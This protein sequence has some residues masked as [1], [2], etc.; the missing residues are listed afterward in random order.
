MITIAGIDFQTKLAAE[1]HI[2]EILERTT[3]HALTRTTLTGGD[4][5][6]VSALLDIHPDRKSIIGSGLESIEVEAIPYAPQQRRFIVRR[7]DGSI[8]D[9]SWRDSLTPRSAL[10]LLNSVLR[11][12]IRT[13]LRIFKAHAFH[14]AENLNCYNECGTTVNFETAHVDHIAPVTFAN[15]AQ[16]WLAEEHLKPED[17]AIRKRTGYE[18]ESTIVD[19]A[20]EGRWQRFHH[21]AA[22]LAIACRTC[23]C[24]PLRRK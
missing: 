9:W 22:K 20:L 6:F 8:R 19:H 10:N 3:P 14:A 7:T 21:A 18:Q 12:S 13:Q 11:R 24:G 16:D 5:L 23:N 15:L 1:H 4:L 2:R 17:I